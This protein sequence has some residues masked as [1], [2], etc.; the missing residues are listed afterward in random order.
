MRETQYRSGPAQANI[1]C[2]STTVER[3]PVR[4]MYEARLGRADP[5]P[6]TGCSKAPVQ[7]FNV[8]LAGK[9][10]YIYFLRQDVVPPWIVL[11]CK[12]CLQ[13]GH[14]SVAALPD[15]HM[16][17]VPCVYIYKKKFFLGGYFL[18]KNKKFLLN[19]FFSCQ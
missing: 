5:A 19:F 1:T 10:H 8:R 3:F 11:L 9:I 15:T 14:S 6:V 18:F 2:C 17:C 12:L 7:C 16:I 4:Q 13:S